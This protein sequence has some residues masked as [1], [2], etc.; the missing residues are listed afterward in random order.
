M[1]AELVRL[2]K[3]GAYFGVATGRG[4]SV[5]RDLQKCLPRS[6]W[7]RTLIGYYN[8]AE[9]AYLNDEGAP[10]GSP[11]VCEALQPVAAE[12]RNQ[13]AL[14]AS[15]HQ[16]DRPYQITL[17]P[18][19]PIATDR[20]WE[21]VCSAIVRTGATNVDVTRSSHSVDILAAGVSKLNVVRRMRAIIGDSPVLVVGDRGRWPG[22]DY[23]LLRESFS[24][25]VDEVSADPNTCWNLGSPGQRGT[26]VTLE[27]LSDLQERGGELR[28]A[29]NSFR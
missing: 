19:R 3:L 8:G 29:L 15:V 12:L 26:A 10:D 25:G 16:E 9:V 1:A 2:S 13:P 4:A 14:A 20:L 28:F 27:Y 5:R 23:A 18:M 17:A 21:L 6:L 22:N 7:S 11:H 24:L